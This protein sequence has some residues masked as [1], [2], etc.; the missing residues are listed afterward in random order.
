M[1]RLFSMNYQR[2]LQYQFVLSE[3][4]IFTSVLSPIGKAGL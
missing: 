3:S 4:L 1:N 2:A